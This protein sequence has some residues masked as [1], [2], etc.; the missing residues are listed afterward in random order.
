MLG[1]LKQ[2]IAAVVVLQAAA[3]LASTRSIEVDLQKRVDGYKSSVYFVNWGIYGRGY[4]INNLPTDKITHIYYAFMNVDESGTVFSGDTWADFEKHYP[5][6]SW[7]ETGENV[8]GSIKPLFALKHQHRHI[9]TLVSIGGYTWS[10]NFAVVAGSETTR[11]NFAKS[12]VTLLGNCGFDGIDIDWE[13]PKTEEEGQNMIL[14]LQAVRDELDSYASQHGAGYH[15]LLSIAAPAGLDKIGRLKLAELGKVLDFVNI[16][17]YD[18]AGAWDKTT[19]H[20]ANV[21]PDTNNTAATPF[22]T[23]DAIQA[24]KKGGVPAEKLMLGIPI[25]SRA[26]E[27]TSGIGKSYNGVGSGSFEPGVYDYK[28]VTCESANH[29]YDKK[30]MAGFCYDPKTKTL[31]T[32]ETPNAVKDKAVWLKSEN[33]GGLMYWEASG[34]KNNSESLISTGSQALGTLDK[35]PNC[36]SYPNSKYDNIKNGMA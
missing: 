11:K 12:A 31:V 10:T 8:Y 29:H 4:N 36:L 28:S 24:Y 32:L 18:Y 17:A 35:S 3:T 16:M 13:Y 22:N 21:F 26:F 7:T 15:F 25:Y 1:F 34:D 14:L 5:T 9:K 30:I 23:N 6:D 20:N 2:S 19:G 27:Q 33:M